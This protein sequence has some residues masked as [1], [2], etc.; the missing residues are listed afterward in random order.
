MP[1]SVSLV[2]SSRDCLMESAAAEEDLVFGAC[3]GNSL[4]RRPARVR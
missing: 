3:L 4:S 1:A 2:R